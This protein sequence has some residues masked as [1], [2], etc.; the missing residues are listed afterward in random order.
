[1]PRSQTVTILFTDLVDSTTHL[2]RLGDEAGAALFQKHH[3][4]L[5]DAIAQNSGEELQWLGDGVLASF[6]S[7]ADAVRCA[8]AIQQ[9]SQSRTNREGRFEVRIGIQVGEVIQ[10]EGGFFGTPLV[11][12]RRLCDRASGGQILCG[13]IVARMLSARQAFKFRELGN[14]DLKG[15]SAQVA[16]CEICYERGDPASMLSRTPFVGRASQLDRLS[17]RL[18]DAASGR[19][20]V[21][22][23]RGEAG[24]GK[25]RLIEEFTTVA[26]GQ[27]ACVLRGACYEGEWQPPYS[28]FAEAIADYVRTNGAD[29]M[30][31]GAPILARIVPLLRGLVEKVAE[32]E[33]LSKDEERFQLLDAVA[34]FLIGISCRAPLVLVLDDLH[35][36]DRGVSDMFR[37]VAQSASQNPILIIG[38]YR[39]AE[40]DRKHPMAPALAGMSRL[41]NFENLSLSGLTAGELGDL[42]ETVGDQAAPNALINTL[43]NVTDGNPLFI[44]ELLLLLVESGKVLGEGRSWTSGFD[45]DELGI[46]EG[47]REVVGR[48]IERLSESARQ[49]LT[50][51]S[52]F[53]GAFEFEV[54]AAAAGLTEDVALDAIDEAV[55]GQLLRQSPQSDRFD[56]THAIIRHTLYAALS[57]PRRVRLHRK[58]AEEMERAWGD[59]A[60]HHAAEVAYQFWRGAVASGQE[61]R[62]AEY[63]IAAAEQAEAACAYHEAIVFIRIALELLGPADGRRSQLLSR[64]GLALAWTSDGEGSR[65]AALEASA[66]IAAAEGNRAA[67]VYLEAVAHELWTGGLKQDAW[68]LAREGLRLAGDQRDMIWVRLRELD[69][70]GEESEDPSNPGI[71][72]D[73]PSQREWRACL[74]RQPPEVIETFRAD[75]RYESRA[76]IISDKSPNRASLTTLAADYRRALLLWQQDAAECEQRGRLNAAVTALGDAAMCHVALGEFSAARAALDRGEA[77]KARVNASAPVPSLNLNLMAAAHDLRMATDQGWQELLEQSNGTLNVLKNPAPENRFGFAMVRACG[78]YFFASINQA[79]MALQWI[80]SLQRAFEDGAPWEPTYNPVVCDSAA[81]LWLLNRREFASILERCISTKLLPPDFRFPMR[82]TRLSMARLCALQDRFDEAVEW[83]KRARVVLDEQGARPLRALADYDEGLMYLRRAERG[84]PERASVLMGKAI[85][86]FNAIGMDGWRK[87]AEALIPLGESRLPASIQ[88]H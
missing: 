43:E 40:V 32:P 38:A 12:A 13:G 70:V 42:L 20:S 29:A 45:V 65:K 16:V 53:N 72:M 47:V 27:G 39:D 78:A 77:L 11:V 62:G 30:G 84:D 9:Q 83:F 79:E 17:A 35:W 56:F 49:L 5:S 19:G 86:Q 33:P 4:L 21:V 67:A 71:R 37:Y 66:L 75:P 74:R 2:E 44:R 46:P 60:S 64:L 73:S 87:R 85:E 18:A 48:R 14:F 26:S 25:T 23:L 8:V 28:P 34:Q 58:I 41:G 69:L 15:I 24:I 22:M 36:A 31:E 1:M 80:G 54:V 55:E 68:K 52:A 61:N 6:N 7:M 10:R 81:A 57:T 50:V 3:K 63:S 82:D 76:E 88:S 51:A 59:K